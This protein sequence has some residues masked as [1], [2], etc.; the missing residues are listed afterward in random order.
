MGFPLTPTVANALLTGMITDTI[1]FRTSNV[2]ADSLRQAAQLVEAGAKLTDVY[3]KAL[4]SQSFS[5]S[6]LWGLA[7]SRLQKK[8]KLAW[9]SITLEDRK[10]ARYS[11][12][13]DA[14]LTNFLSAIEKTDVVVLFNEQINCKIKV[15]WRSSAGIDVS[16][17]AQRFGGGGHPPASGAEITGNLGDVEK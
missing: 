7:L 15:S 6:L 2:S 4:V 11:G 13:D 14:D 5:A 3:E 8:G 17:I 16:K 1:G 12:R 9:T 10:K